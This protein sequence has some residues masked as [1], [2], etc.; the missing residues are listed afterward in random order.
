MGNRK[1]VMIT[2][3][4]LLSAGQRLRSWSVTFHW[5]PAGSTYEN[6]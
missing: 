4:T 6:Q 5:K 2:W 3:L 1:T